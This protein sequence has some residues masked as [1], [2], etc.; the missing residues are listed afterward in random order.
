MARR[1]QTLIPRHRRRP[2]TLSSLAASSLGTPALTRLAPREQEV[3]T[4][5]YLH[6]EVTAKEIESALAHEI[7]NSA[8]RCML[9]RLVAK[10]ILRR[11]KGHGKTFVYSPALTS[12]DV[13]ERALERVAE[14][15]FGGSLEQAMQRL[16]GLLQKKAPETL[17][18]ISREIDTS[19]APRTFSPLPMAASG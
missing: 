18:A 6:T 15:Y 1:K 9:G 7:G 14:D 10:G 11:R 2:A 17:H 12:P 16:V 8:I 19:S 4:I 3:A 5:V 13:Q